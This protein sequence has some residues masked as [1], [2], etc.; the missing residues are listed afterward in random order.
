MIL[1]FLDL[2]IVAI[3][4]IQTLLTFPL[5][6][7]RVEIYIG[8]QLGTVCSDGFDIADAEVAC[9]QLGFYGAISYNNASNLG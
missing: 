1:L 8:N 3:D 5:N 9:R 2:R 7:G 6:A 4:E